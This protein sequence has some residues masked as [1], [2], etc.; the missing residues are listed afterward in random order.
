MIVKI[1]MISQ[2]NSSDPEPAGNRDQPE[3]ETTLYVQHT[4]NIIT[5]PMG[6]I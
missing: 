3:I 4:E 5:P 6:V 1:E 2:I